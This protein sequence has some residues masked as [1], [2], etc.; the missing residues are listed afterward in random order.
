MVKHS[1]LEIVTM[2]YGVITVLKHSVEHGGMHHAI[3]LTKY[4]VHNPGGNNAA[5]VLS[6]YDGSVFRH[7]TKIQMKI[8]PKRCSNM[9]C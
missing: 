7:Y 2:I 1:A 9:Y 4:D 3:M 8:C 5:R 6:W